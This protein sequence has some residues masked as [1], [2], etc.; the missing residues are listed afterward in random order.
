MAVLQQKS[1]GG[2]P[3]FS[4]DRVS[5]TR[6]PARIIRVLDQY[7]VERRKYQSEDME[8]RDVAFRRQVYH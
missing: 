2:N 3:A 8:L 7:G 5:Q 1:E 4:T 6:Y